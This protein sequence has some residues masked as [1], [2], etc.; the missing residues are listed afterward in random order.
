[1]EDVD[2]FNALLLFAI[3]NQI[4]AMNASANA[5]F[6]IAG[7]QGEGVVPIHQLVAGFEE[8]VDKAVGA[9]FGVACN[10]LKYGDQICLS[11]CSNDNLHA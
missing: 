1:V 11:C 9:Q 4:P 5:G 6:F 10:I 8:V 2:D 3:K 7:H